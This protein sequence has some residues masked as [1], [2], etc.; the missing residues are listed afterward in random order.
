MS[1]TIAK[2]WV[3]VAL[4]CAAA[5][6]AYTAWRMSV[7]DDAMGDAINDGIHAMITDASA[8]IRAANDVSDHL[9]A[10]TDYVIATNTRDIS[11]LQA[12]ESSDP[13][14]QAM[15]IEQS[16]ADALPANV[17]KTEFPQRF[18]KRTGEFNRTADARAV[19]ASIV[20]KRN[21]NVTA[22][23][24][25][26]QQSRDKTSLLVVL[27]VGYAL[28]ILLVSLTELIEIPKANFVLALIG[29]IVSGA[30]VAW[31]VVIEAGVR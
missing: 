15:Y 27:L 19:Y 4:M 16:E 26:S 21:V 18:V 13:E 10:Y 23:Y 2:I 22:V 3:A 12:D 7:I 29:I 11:L 24:A 28:V 8:R 5:G 14:V 20:G 9:R 1:D 30:L 6:G 31:T 17:A 25:E